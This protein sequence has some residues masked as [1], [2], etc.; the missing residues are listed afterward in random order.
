MKVKDLMFDEVLGRLVDQRG[1]RDQRARHLA[2]VANA[3][4]QV[5]TTTGLDNNC[6][7]AELD[8]QG[9]VQS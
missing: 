7:P 9:K 8:A 1:S 3:L 5:V 2:S 6:S 4:A